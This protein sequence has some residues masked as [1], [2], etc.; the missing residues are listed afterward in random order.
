MSLTSSLRQIRLYCT[1]HIIPWRSWRRV[2]YAWYWNRLC[3]WS[4]RSCQVQSIVA[5]IRIPS[6]RV[7][8]HN[9]IDLPTICTSIP[10]IY[11]V[12][13]IDHRPFSTRLFRHPYDH[14]YQTT[15]LPDTSG[16]L[17]IETFDD[18]LLSQLQIQSRAACSS[19]GI[20]RA[21]LLGWIC[22]QLDFADEGRSP[23]DACWR[24][25]F[26]PRWIVDV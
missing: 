1:L 14:I 18:V 21:H 15:Y 25:Y 9:T 3:W 22:D 8:F 24:R 4:R 16:V 13:P 20:D 7:V 19:L 2:R 11:T 6:V 10:T 5:V 12:I 23:C 26:V 17:H